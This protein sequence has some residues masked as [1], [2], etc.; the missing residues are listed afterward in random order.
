MLLAFSELAGEKKRLTLE[1]LQLTI[2]EQLNLKSCN[3]AYRSALWK[4]GEHKCLTAFPECC[5]RTAVEMR[6]YQRN[7]TLSAKNRVP[8]IDDSPM[9]KANERS[10]KFFTPKDA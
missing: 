10:K 8:Q 3:S 2:E 6:E 5:R 7:L 1:D 9:D 4:S